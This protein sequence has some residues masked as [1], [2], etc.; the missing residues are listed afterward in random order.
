MMM[1]V[2]KMLGYLNPLTEMSAIEDSI[3]CLDYLSKYK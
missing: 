3:L 2:F 1:K